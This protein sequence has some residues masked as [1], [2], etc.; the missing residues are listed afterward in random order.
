MYEEKLG[1]RVT[2]YTYN[3]LKCQ[4]KKSGICEFRYNYNILFYNIIYNAFNNKTANPV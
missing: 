1:V 4:M 3:R 2:I